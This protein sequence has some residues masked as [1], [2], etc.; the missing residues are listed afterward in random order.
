M[1]RRALGWDIHRD[2]EGVQAGRRFLKTLPLPE[3]SARA[4]RGY[5]DVMHILSLSIAEV[6]RWD[7]VP[8]YR[9]TAPTWSRRFGR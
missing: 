9:R 1:N 7:E 3:G 4:L 5:L 6:V 8:P 2:K